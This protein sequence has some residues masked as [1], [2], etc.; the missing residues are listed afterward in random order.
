VKTGLVKAE[1]DHMRTRMSDNAETVVVLEDPYL[2]IVA[3]SLE[4]AGYSVKT[5]RLRID[6]VLIDVASWDRC[7]YRPPHVAASSALVAHRSRRR[8]E[9]AAE[10]A[11][12]ADQNLCSVDS[13]VK[14]YSIAVVV[15]PIQ[16]HRSCRFLSPPARSDVRRQ[17]IC[18]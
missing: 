1:Q 13:L 3:T 12:R 6:T 11:L 17:Y 9:E 5:A 14:N 2:R 15:T 10:K 16:E 7:L 8:G 4:P 18:C